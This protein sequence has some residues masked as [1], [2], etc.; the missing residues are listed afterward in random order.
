MEF[1][2]V[3]A[4]P[5][6]KD[7]AALVPAPFEHLKTLNVS[8]ALTVHHFS[9]LLNGR[10]PLLRKLNLTLVRDL[11][12]IQKI[13]AAPGSQVKELDF[14]SLRLKIPGVELLV[15]K[16]HLKTLQLRV[17]HSIE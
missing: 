5:Q 10:W 13:V 4:P 17:C 7:I 2:C 9:F 6:S 3:Q 11:C 1:S 8:S 14:R 15:K 16:W 12:L